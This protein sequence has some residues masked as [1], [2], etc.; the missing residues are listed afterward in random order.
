MGHNKQTKDTEQLIEENIDYLF[1]FAFFRLGNREEAE[2][3]V[4]ETF[5]RFLTKKEHV[6]R[7]KSRMY[8]FRILYNLCN[9]WYRKKGHSLPLESIKSEIVDEDDREL[10]EE[11]LRIEKLLLLLP[12]NQQE[13]IRMHTVDALMF[14][15]IADILEEPVTTIKSRYQS[16]MKQLKKL[17]TTH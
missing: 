1:R 5:L 3:A 7:Q 14:T 17:L 2:D 13:V 8:L 6:D 15:E 9:S 12:H 11:F 16:G 4:Q 10:Q